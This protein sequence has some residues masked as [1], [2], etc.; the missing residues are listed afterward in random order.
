[1]KQTFER[2]TMISS[3]IYSRIGVVNM[4]RKYTNMKE[5]LRHVKTR[6]ATAFITLSRI[7]SQKVN[8]RRMFTSDEWA[9]SKWVKKARAKRVVEVLL[10]PSF[11][12]NV[13]F[14]FKIVGPLV[15]VLRLVDGERK[16]DMCYI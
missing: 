11:L 13:V 5:L 6:F 9:K 2:A 8:I 7:H 14:V 12:N 15:G 4:L 10:M 16:H 3:Y 1:M